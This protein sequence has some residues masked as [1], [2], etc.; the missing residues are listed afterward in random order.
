MSTNTAAVIPKP[1]VEPQLFSARTV[2]LVGL[3][4]KI[5]YTEL[6]WYV[7]GGQIDTVRI[8]EKEHSAL[9]IFLYAKDAEPYQKFLKEAEIKFRG[10]RIWPTKP[11]EKHFNNTRLR[12]P[13]EI[14]L[15][16]WSRCILVDN[17]PA[18]TT[19]EG[20]KRD[21]KKIIGVE[22]DYEKFE[23]KGISARL[24]TTAIVTAMALKDGLL[25]H[26]KYKEVYISY[27]KDPCDAN[28]LTIYESVGIM[29]H[30]MVRLLP[31]RFN[32]L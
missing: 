15:R 8:F 26:P 27:E 6:G 3:P 31:P 22:L 4:P 10:C 21:L 29:G 17:L 24:W 32:N 9:V 1:K 7:K 2:L 16:G 5:T 19:V 20:L 14:K 13:D 11:Q 28:L 18:G 30:H 25:A 23:L 12:Q